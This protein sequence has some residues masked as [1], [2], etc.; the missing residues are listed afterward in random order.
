MGSSKGKVHGILFAALC[1]TALAASLAGCA[2]GSGE[3]TV[4]VSEGGASPTITVT[5]NSEV[6]VVPDKAEVGIALTSQAATAMDAQEQNTAGVSAVIDALEALG[7]DEKSINDDEDAFMELRMIYYLSRLSGFDL[8]ENK[9]LTANE[10]FTMGTR[11]A[12]RSLGY[13]GMLGA[14]LPGMKA[15]VVLLDLK[16]IEHKPVV[17]PGADPAQT[18]I[19]RAFGR[20]VTDVFVN[21]VH[22]VENGKSTLI[23][24]EALYKEV[25]DFAAK[26]QSEERKAHA[27]NMMKLKP[28]MQA[29]YKDMDDF[30]RKPYY[31]VN[32]KV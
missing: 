28:Y 17:V 29:W 15:D 1:A 5:A 14:L 8:V 9:A 27:A 24:E 32:S 22:V 2:T 10:V 20:H 18:M 26:P 19:H 31:L 7:I 16:E 21:G 30:E 13:E 23:D 4:V 25:A 3:R 11:N 12:A 6:S